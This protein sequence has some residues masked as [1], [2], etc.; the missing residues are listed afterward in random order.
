MRHRHASVSAGE[1]YRTYRNPF[2]RFRVQIISLGFID[3]AQTIVDAPFQV[4][5]DVKMGVAVFVIHSSAF[6]CDFLNGVLT[7]RCSLVIGLCGNLPLYNVLLRFCSF[8]LGVNVGWQNAQDFAWV[9]R[10]ELSS[11]SALDVLQ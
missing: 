7:F 10:G 4:E 8:G 1:H 3:T 6:L 9:L 11:M 2:H 5:L